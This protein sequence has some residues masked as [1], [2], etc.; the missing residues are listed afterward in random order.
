[1]VR[2]TLCDIF[3]EAVS[4]ASDKP[5][6]IFGDSIWSYRELDQKSFGLAAAMQ[7]AGVRQGDR[8][9]IYGPKCGWSV[10]FILAALRLG[11]IYAPIEFGT[12]D[13]IFAKIVDSSQPRLICVTAPDNLR[14]KETMD[15]LSLARVGPGD[16]I[17]AEPVLPELDANDPAYILFTSGTTGDPKGIVHTHDSA[18][19]FV[20]WAVKE[21]GA[22]PEDVF[23]NHASFGF[24][25]SVFDLF[26]AILVGAPLVIFSETQLRFAGEIVRMISECKVTIWY[27]VPTALIQLYDLGAA[28][29]LNRLRV[30][31]FA[32]EVFP[33]ERLKRFVGAAPN[34]AYYNFFGPTE[35]NVF[36]YWKVDPGEIAASKEIP[37]GFPCPYCDVRL[38]GEGEITDLEQGEMLVAGRNVMQGYWQQGRLQTLARDK[39]VYDQTHDN[40]YFRTGDFAVRDSQQRLWF[41]GRKDR[42]IKVRGFRVELDSVEEGLMNIEG[43]QNAAAVQIIKDSPKLGALVTTK[44]GKTLDQKTVMS[45][46]YEIMRPQD[47]PDILLVVDRIPHNLRGKRDYVAIAQ[48]LEEYCDE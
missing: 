24:D 10:A 25:L 6:L 11:A 23:S 42:Q 48:K 22:G 40:T 20:E 28:S 35:T 36:T 26:G 41:K 27:S 39:V 2:K 5:A 34:P 15:K 45:R 12:P 38:V 16:I 30:I 9:L 43:L 31:I 14:V 32:G 18:M 19:A 8:V 1:M 44:N 4:N 13:N 17:D 33:L 7:R 46:A 21:V 29:E 3:N 37:I 47:I